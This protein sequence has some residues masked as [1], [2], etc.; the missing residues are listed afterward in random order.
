LAVAGQGIRIQASLEYDRWSIGSTLRPLSV[1]ADVDDLRVTIH[2]TSRDTLYKVISP[3]IVS[4]VKRTII[5]SIESNLQEWLTILD[6]QLTSFKGSPRARK[7]TRN[8]TPGV[9]FL[10][11]FVPGF[12]RRSRG[13]QTPRRSHFPLRR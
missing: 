1:R 13:I 6:R 5:T 10:R 3:A 11:R 7:P 9:G 8:Q 12:L 2:H 4:A